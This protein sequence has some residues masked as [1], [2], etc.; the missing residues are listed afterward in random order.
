[1]TGWELSGD[2]NTI[3]ATLPQIRASPGTTVNL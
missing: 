2:L 3:T 1:M